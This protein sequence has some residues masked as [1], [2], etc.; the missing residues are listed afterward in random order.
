VY[1][2]LA[3]LTVIAASVYIC[4]DNELDV[5]ETVQKI[6]FN[7]SITSSLYIGISVVIPDL[8]SVNP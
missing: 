1:M 2:L 6:V 8:V 5:A 7:G 4:M 3:V